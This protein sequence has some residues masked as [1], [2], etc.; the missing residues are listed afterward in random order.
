MGGALNDLL[1]F[2]WSAALVTRILIRAATLL[3]SAVYSVLSL[4]RYGRVKRAV[5]ALAIAALTALLSAA[6]W[7]ALSDRRPGPVWCRRLMCWNSARRDLRRFESTES[8]SE[9][10]RLIEGVCGKRLPTVNFPHVDL[11]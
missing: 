2:S 8:G 9:V 1:L 5:A 3:I 10:N 4:W 7:R 11:S 6:L